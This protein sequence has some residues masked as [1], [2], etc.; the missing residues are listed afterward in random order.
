MQQYFLDYQLEKYVNPSPVIEIGGVT[1]ITTQLPMNLG[2]GRVMKMLPGCG[3]GFESVAIS[4][5][6]FMKVDP[7]IDYEIS[8]WFKQETVNPAWYLRIHT[9]D[10]S[11]NEFD[12]FNIVNGAPENQFV[13]YEQAVCEADQWHFA[14]F[15]L[16]GANENIQFGM[17]PITSLAMG[18]N[19]KM[20][21]KVSQILVD[22]ATFSTDAQDTTLLMYNFKVKPLRTPF[23]RGF[24]QGSDLLINWR[25]NR[26]TKFTEKQVDDIATDFLFPYNTAN[27]SINLIKQ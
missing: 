7:F 14:R 15:I 17:Q 20:N 12:A 6:W 19:L 3:F 18:K 25:K 16:Y 11:D 1:I 2:A 22:L 4:K 24:V 9:F 5:K 27:K 23:S 8:F 26:S 10:C 21:K 13:G